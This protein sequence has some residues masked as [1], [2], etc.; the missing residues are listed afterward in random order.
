MTQGKYSFLSS[1]S[2]RELAMFGG[3]VSP[4]VPE[5]VKIAIENKLKNNSL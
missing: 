1:S 3:D 4:F 5:N 2:V